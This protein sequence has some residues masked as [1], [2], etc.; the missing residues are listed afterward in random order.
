L[1]AHVPSHLRNPVG[2]ARRLLASRDPAAIQAML[3]TA[4]G[5]LAL[6]LDLALRRSEQRRYRDAAPPTRPI[7][8]VCGA[9]RAGTTVLAQLL[10]AQL[11]VA[12]LRNLTQLFPRSPLT[13]RAI[14]GRFLRSRP[15]THSFY[16]R[17][18]GLSGMNDALQIWDR[19]LDPERRVPTDVL[20]PERRDGMIRFFGAFE[21]MTGM[22]A[23]NKN[24]SLD[25]QAA[26]VGEALPTARFVCV[27]RDPIF[28]AQSLLVAR[29]DILGD[30]QRAYGVDDPD[31]PAGLDPIDDVCRQVRFHGREQQRQHQLLGPER[32]RFVAYEKL[33]VDPAA[34]IREIATALDLPLDEARLAGV[35]PLGLRNRVRIPPADF[36]RIEDAL[37]ELGQ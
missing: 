18:T 31:A 30:E 15:T 23:L 27:T 13:A 3:F 22:P 20:T 19:W 29:S 9:P 33:C 2:L 4:G 12:Y 8:L 11:P 6:P 14:F 25:V 10:A 21:A 26:P 24:N 28:L 5:L 17:T 1:R 32:F 16:G 7:V 36:K 35:E 37:S 34:H